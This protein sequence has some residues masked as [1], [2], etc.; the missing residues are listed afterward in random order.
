MKK[1]TNLSN[2][3][4]GS[5]HNDNHLFDTFDWKLALAVVVMIVACGVI[6]LELVY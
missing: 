3:I 2:E 1:H 6:L 4:T 5:Y